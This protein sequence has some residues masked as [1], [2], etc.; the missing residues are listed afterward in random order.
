MPP[1]SALVIDEVLTIARL[2]MWAADRRRMTSGKVQNYKSRGWTERRSSEADAAIVRTIDFEKALSGL[3]ERE[4]AAVVMRYVH[5]QSDEKTATVIG[6]SLRTVSTLVPQARR[7][8][9]EILAK[10][11]LY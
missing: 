6:C 1:M 8:L 5:R 9:A 10:A 2:R 3:T 11:D 7:K 4:Q